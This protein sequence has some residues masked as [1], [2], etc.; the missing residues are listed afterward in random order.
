MSKEYCQKQAE[1]SS[2]LEKVERIEHIMYDNGT[3]GIQTQMVEMNT[4]MEQRSKTD[5]KIATALNGLLKFQTETEVTG[6]NKEKRQIL[7]L[8]IIGAFF[9]GLGLVISLFF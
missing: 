7:N 1:I 3:K 4:N 9:T 2:L 5:E 8:A 6:R